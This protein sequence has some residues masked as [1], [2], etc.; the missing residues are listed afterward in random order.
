MTRRILSLLLFSLFLMSASAFAQNDLALSI[1]GT[2]T[3][4]ATAT[5]NLA[6]NCALNPANCSTIKTSSKTSYEATLSLRLIG[7]KAASISLELP[8]MGV[9]ART[10]SSSTTTLPVPRDFSS[11][12]FTPSIRFR[13][14]ST[15]GISPFVSVGGGFAHFGESKLLTNFTTSVLSTGTNTTAFQ[16]GG[17][18]DLKTPIPHLGFRGEVREFLTGHPTSG[19]SFSSRQQNLFVGGGVVLRF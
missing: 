2:F 19:V 18:V 10:V 14:L 16:V 13:V 8:L 17:G 3:P 15:A 11:F 1:G 7:A 4:D 12:F 6:T 9:P 5:G